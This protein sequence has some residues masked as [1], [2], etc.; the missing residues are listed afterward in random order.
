MLKR[1]LLAYCRGLD[2]PGKLRLVGWLARWCLPARGIVLNICGGLRMRLQVIN[3]PERSLFLTG[4][5]EARTTRFVISNLATGSF[6]AVAGANI[7][8]YVLQMARA[9]GTTGRV[10]GVEPLPANFARCWENIRLNPELASRVVLYGCALGGT[11]GYLPMMAPPEEN[12]GAATLDHTITASI[13]RV[14]VER[15]DV[16]V[17]DLR[18]PP[19]DL[20][21][22]DIEGWE[23]EAAAGFGSAKPG[24]LV[25]E[26]DPRAHARH[27]RTETDF[28]AA[29]QQ[30]GYALSHF[31]G[32]PARAGDFFPEQTIVAWLPDNPPRWI[33]S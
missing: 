8:Y 19:P 4:T 23:L 32:R 9:V 17:G 11:G 7:G 3:N 20:M 1:F 29:L 16:L 24:I 15:L 5:Y 18:F 2:H 13:A 22:L 6:A 26:N 27:R 12:T 10:L 33:E 21:V 28:L 30:L 14:R 31:D 25:V